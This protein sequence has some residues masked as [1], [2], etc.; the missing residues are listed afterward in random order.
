ME[1]R[2]A[3]AVF[4]VLSLLGLAAG[5]TPRA[6]A[7]QSGTITQ[8]WLD[9]MLTQWKPAQNVSMSFEVLDNRVGYGNIALSY[10]TLQVQTAN[11]EMVMSTNAQC[12]RMDIGY[13]P[14]LQ[15]NQT[16]I[17]IVS[18][19]VQDV[20]SAGKC[21]II[22]DAGS[23][24]YRH[25]GQLTWSQFQAA[26][27]PRVTTLASLYH[28]DYY[29]VIKEPG[30]YVPMVSDAATNPEFSNATNWVNLSQSLAADV[31]K[32]S[33]SSKVGV[34]VAADSLGSN[35]SLYVPFLNGVV[36][37]AD[38]SFVGYDIYT[39]TGFTSTQNFL[40]Q[41]GSGGKD[42]WI[43][44]A[45][46]GDGNFVFDPTRAALDKEWM[47]VVY[48]FAETIHAAALMPFY[49]DLMAS[50]SLNGTSPTVPSDIISLYSQR[51]PVY[52]EFQSI[53]A[54]SPSTS[55][56][57]SSTQSSSTTSSSS[58]STS[59]RSSA[60]S[61]S[62]ISSSTTSTTSRSSLSSSPSQSASYTTL[63]PPTSTAPSAGRS[64]LLAVAALVVILI[65]VALYL[66]SRRLK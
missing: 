25:G 61:S 37:L 23:E 43:A 49:T 31:L 35:P 45:W 9:Q 4:L 3:C 18:T 34:S 33:P 30:W 53:I 62:T 1:L 16:Q 2:L 51:T 58:S 22:A 7:Q 8:Q 6:Q 28:P 13:A 50:Y 21:L 46:S 56:S 27:G 10:D 60:S 12:V 5:L 44:E 59:S 38:V 65:I 54:A 24:T 26:W 52:Y 17:K 63:S 29:I 11:L 42:I 40:T 41:N 48:Y 47:Q 66:V 39:T 14:W 55:T 32:V 20:R 19:L 64:V 36:K 57:S 15:N